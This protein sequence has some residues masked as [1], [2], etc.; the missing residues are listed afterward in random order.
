MGLNDYKINS[1]SKPVS[2][3]DDTPQMSA[4]ELKE[5]FDSNSANELKNSVN[6]I[7]D[8]LKD[9]D[10]SK[11]HTHDNKDILD[12]ITEVLNE[13]HDSLTLQIHDE[14]VHAENTYATKEEVSIT[15]ATKTELTT[16]ANALKEDINEVADILSNIETAL[17]D[18]IDS[19]GVLMFYLEYKHYLAPI[20]T[21]SDF[22]NS[23]YNDGT[24][25]VLEEN[26]MS[27]VVVD[28]LKVCNIMADP[29]RLTDEIMQSYYY[30]LLDVEEM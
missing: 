12:N 17:D 29:V 11:Q 2:A 23:T 13:T 14:H 22:I 18:I 9:V 21:W 20:G 5:W 7:I 3:L 15:Y 28:D 24:F 30:K 1:F 19:K 27:Y 26:G 25:M 8:E 6:G 16:K 10:V 4:A